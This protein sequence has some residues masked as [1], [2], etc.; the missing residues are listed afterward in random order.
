MPEYFLYSLLRLALM[1][2]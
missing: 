2:K 1:R